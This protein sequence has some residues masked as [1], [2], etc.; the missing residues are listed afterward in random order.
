MKI[1]L[2]FVSNSSSSSFAI[3]KKYLSP[4]QIQL[5]KDHKNCG[6]EYADSDPWEIRE[7][8][9]N[10]EGSTTMANFD[11]HEYLKKIGVKEEWI[12]L[13]T[14]FCWDI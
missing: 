11:F 5:I 7:R 14:E 1:R 10:I 6:E 8:K 13:G 3:N 12:E 2:Y 9:N 4:Y